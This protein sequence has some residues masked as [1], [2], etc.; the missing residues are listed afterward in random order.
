M[1]HRARRGRRTA[2]SAATCA[3]RA[4]RRAR[5]HDR[6]AGQQ[7][8]VD[9]VGRGE[10]RLGT[11]H[12]GDEQPERGERRRCRARPR[13]APPSE[14]DVGRV[15]A[16]GEADRRRSRRSAAPRRA[17]A[18]P[19]L[20]S[21]QPG[22]GERGGAEPL[23]DAVPPL[24]AGRDRQRGERRRH[25]RQ[26]EHAG[27]EDVDRTVREVEARGGRHPSTPPISTITGI[28]TASSSCSPLRSISRAS[29]AAWA[30]TICGERRGARGAGE[31]E[32]VE[33]TTPAPVRSARGRRPRGCA[34]RGSA[35]PA[36]RRCSSHQR[37]T[38][39]Q[40]SRRRPDR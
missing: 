5:Q 17:A 26:R 31:V 36:A 12:A 7:Q 35:T 25:H 19:T 37:E 11:Q 40:A 9:Q 28:T 13:A 33:L 4:V 27:G 16:E 22:A 6:A 14:A 10:G 24:E 18:P 34:G 38:T 20:P 23:D 3:E 21:E 39:G 2:A 29:I 15:P 32:L 1:P 30:S 8:Q